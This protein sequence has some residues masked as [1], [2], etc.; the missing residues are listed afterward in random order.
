MAALVNGQPIWLVDYEKE[1][2]R[3]MQAQEEL[4]SAPTGDGDEYTQVVLE[5]LIE[6]K[7]IG[8]AAEEN[9]VVVTTVMVAQ[10]VEELKESAGGEDNFSAWLEANQWTE[11]E[12]HLALRTEMIT[13][14][15]VDLITADVPFT[16]EQVHARYIQVDDAD[17]AQTLLDQVVSGADFGDLAWQHSLDRITGEDAGDLGFFARGSLLVPE[18]EDAAFALQPG[19]VSAVVA[20]PRADG[21]GTAYYLVQ[22][23]ERDPQ[24]E[25]TANLR[26][27]LLQEKFENWLAEQWNRAEI[28]RYIS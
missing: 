23:I 12:F 2:A 28:D 22:L 15:M 19:E 13:E 6:T 8:Q 7:L 14:Q 5:A 9:G 20:A 16:A 1:L 4:G 3:F 11:E 21:S 24:K 18:V 17:L 26:S 27:I 10:R 25:I